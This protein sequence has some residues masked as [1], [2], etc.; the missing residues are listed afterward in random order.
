MER[1]Q[2]LI[3]E[4]KVN[5]K[6]VT[7]PNG[8]MPSQVTFIIN[9][10]TVNKRHNQ[11]LHKVYQNNAELYR[12]VN[13]G[14]S[15]ATLHIRDNFISNYLLAVGLREYGNINERASLCIDDIHSASQTV[16]AVDVDGITAMFS[17]ISIHGEFYLVAGT[18]E[19]HIVFNCNKHIDMYVKNG[20]YVQND[21]VIT[22]CKMIMRYWNRLSDAKRTDLANNLMRLKHTVV[23][24]I[25][26]AKHIGYTKDIKFDEAMMQFTNLEF[27]NMV[28]I[29][30]TKVDL[31]KN[32]SLV[33]CHPVTMFHRLQTEYL[34][35][36]PKY[37][38]VSK[39]DLTRRIM[40]LDNIPWIKGHLLYYVNDCHETKCMVRHLSKWFF[41]IK[42]TIN[43][44]P[45]RERRF[46]AQ[47]L[48]DLV[49][50]ELENS[51]RNYSQNELHCWGRLL[52]SWFYWK[53]T[54]RHRN[55]KNPFIVDWKRLTAP[56][57]VINY[58]GVVMEP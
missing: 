9:N 15:F 53:F 39:A 35:N 31:E 33:A 2:K 20:L 26:N 41:A 18:T 44:T 16:V 12:F 50:Q 17:G 21:S 51:N 13:R 28:G 40:Q 47:V 7:V 25:L 1:I 56:T 43:N 30:L 27:P 57:T 48:E 38:V 55:S 10:V 11:N 5:I 49:V 52:L 3:L 45:T 34:L 42:A 54:T 14:L 32:N 22:I 6:K 46:N 36:I 4:N 29:A 58:N 24:K 37:E 23:L 19:E 8:I